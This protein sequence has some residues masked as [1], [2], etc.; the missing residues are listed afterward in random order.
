[1]SANFESQTIDTLARIETKMDILV[2]SDGNGG[3]MADLEVRMRRQENHIRRSWIR[4][5]SFASVISA[6]ISGLITYVVNYFSH[7][8]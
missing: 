4:P 7:A 2:G 3:R 5:A 8:H 6:A 1:M